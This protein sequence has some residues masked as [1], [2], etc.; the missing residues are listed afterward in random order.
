MTKRPVMRYSRAGTKPDVTVVSP[1]ATWLPRDATLARFRRAALGRKP[2]VLAP[3]DDAWRRIIPGFEL[4]R[5]PDDE[6][7]LP[8]SAHAIASK[9]AA[10]PC[11]EVSELVRAGASLQPL[12]D[13]GIL[14]GEDVPLT[15][16]PGDPAALDGW[17]FA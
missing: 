16:T 15:V 5:T 12:L 10:M 2:T 13:A 7:A 4:L 8:A 17:R 3:R 14:A 9:L 6:L 11:I 1:L